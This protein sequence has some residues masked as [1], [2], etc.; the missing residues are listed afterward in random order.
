VTPFAG[1]VQRC[2]VILQQMQPTKVHSS[3]TCLNS[4]L[5]SETLASADD[6]NCTEKKLQ[7]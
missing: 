1:N 4:Y 7:N 5:T 6:N 2:Y 3:T